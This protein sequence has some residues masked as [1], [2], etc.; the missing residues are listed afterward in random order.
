MGV[1]SRSATRSNGP[2]AIRGNAARDQRGEAGHGDAPRYDDRRPAP[3]DLAVAL[4]ECISTDA[5]GAPAIVFS[6]VVP[7]AQPALHLA[8]TTGMRRG[9]VVGLRWGDWH[10]C[11]HRI[12]IARSRQSIQGGTIEVP[13]KTTASRRSICL[14]PTT[15]QILARWRRRLERDGHPPPA[16]V[17]RRSST[18]RATRSTPSHSRN[19]STARSPAAVSPGS[20]SMTCDTPTPHSS[21][22][23]ACRS[24][25]CP[26]DSATPTPASRWPPTNTS[27]PA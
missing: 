3:R 5:P 18:P 16:S 19:S 24:R 25:S 21:S 2:A 27:C 23:P 15:E 6:T 7:A 11:D 8:A 4:E 17:T 26:N 14:D 1:G 10:R 22:P 9:E 12:S 20:D 13:T